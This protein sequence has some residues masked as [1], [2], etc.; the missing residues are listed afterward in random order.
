MRMSHHNIVKLRSRSNALLF[1]ALVAI[2]P[3]GCGSDDEIGSDEAARR[4]YLGLDPSIGKSLKL[5]FDGF[6]AASSANIPNQTTMGEDRGTLVISGQVD[7]GASDNKGM[8]L[9]VGMTDYSDGKIVVDEDG[10]TIEIIYNTA[11]DAAAQPTLNLKLT[12]IPTGTFSGGLSGRFEMTD[13]L[14][15]SVNLNL[16]FSGQ[17]EDAGGGLVRRKPGATTVTG[18]AISGDSTY[19]V[20]VTI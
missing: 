6:N 10:K 18:T 11:M 7:Q 17:L 1:C 8:R 20:N 5:G 13:G 9:Q 2:A 12:K 19:N 4:A 14:K 15:G 3:V 16:M